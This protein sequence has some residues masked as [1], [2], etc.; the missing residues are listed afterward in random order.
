MPLTLVMRETSRAADDANCTDAEV[1]SGR[2]SPLVRW[3]SMAYVASIALMIPI[4]VSYSAN[5]TGKLT[6][7]RIME[8]P[9]DLLMARRRQM[10]HPSL[11]N[12][13]GWGASGRGRSSPCVACA[14][15]IPRR[16][17]VSHARS[18]GCRGVDGRPQRRGRLV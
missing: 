9:L 18:A 6:R 16:G 7:L 12:V 5:N 13:T 3:H 8:R 14:V 2:R 10:P 11:L 4:C 17:G 1:Q 15:T